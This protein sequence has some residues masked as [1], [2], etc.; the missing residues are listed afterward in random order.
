MPT[1]RKSA[2][3]IPEAGAVGCCVIWLLGTEHGSS[4]IVLSSLN[5]NLSNA[6]TYIFY[7]SLRIMFN[8]PFPSFHGEVI[9][10]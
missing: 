7:Q 2:I 10:F 8:T 6:Q 1:E 9:N 3:R 5:H 4:A